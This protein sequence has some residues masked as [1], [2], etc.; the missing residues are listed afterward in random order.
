MEFI[1]D[2]AKFTVRECQ[3]EKHNVRK[4]ERIIKNFKHWWDQMASNKVISW[5]HRRK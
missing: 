2:R 4:L 5:A 1:L 3:E